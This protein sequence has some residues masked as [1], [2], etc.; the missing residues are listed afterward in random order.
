MKVIKAG[1]LARLKE[2]LTLLLGRTTLYSCRN[3]LE[4]NWTAKPAP[5]GAVDVM[6]HVTIN[7][8]TYGRHYIVPGHALKDGC[9][10]TVLRSYMISCA[11]G[12]LKDILCGTKP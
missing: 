8:H 6:L 10:E 5:D 7:K 4:A 1:F 2:A 11:S 9:R 3:G 12:L